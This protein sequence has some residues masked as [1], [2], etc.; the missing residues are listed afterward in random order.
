LDK[1][2]HFDRIDNLGEED[3]G[4]EGITVFHSK[5]DYDEVFGGDD[6][7]VLTFIALAV[8]AVLRNVWVFSG[9]G[10][11]G[12]TW[13]GGV[14]PPLGS[15]FAFSFCI[16]GFGGSGSKLY[17]T[18]REDAF[19]VPDAVIQ[20]EQPEAGPIAGG[21]IAIR[22]SYKSASGIGLQNGVVHAQLKE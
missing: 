12:I 21:G 16:P 14:Y 15:I 1:G 6:P 19:A 2:L 8:E 22:R 11:G 9:T 4:V 20:I 13:I 5:A 10:I 17:P 7:A 3:I 18:F